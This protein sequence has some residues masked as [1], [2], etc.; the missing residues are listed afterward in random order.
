MPKN[1]L[2]IGPTGVGKTEISRR[3]A[4]LAGA[5]FIK[6]EAT[7]FT[8][9]GYVGR[10]V[11]QIM[12]DLVEVGIELVREKKREEV[13][14][15]A[16]LERRGARA[17]RAGRQDGQPGDARFVPQEAA[18]RANS[19]T[20]RSRSRSP[21]AATRWAASRFPACPAPIS[22]CST[23]TTCSARRFGQRTKTR[24]TTVE[25]VLRP[26]DRRRIR[27]AARQGPGGD[28]RRCRVGRE[29][30][31]RLPRRDRQDRARATATIGRQRLARRRAARPA[32]AGRGHDGRHQVRAGEDRPHPVHRVGRLPRRQAVGPAC[33]NCRAA[34]RSAS[35]CRR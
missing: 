30:R 5:P 34:C 4:K 7:K 21:T 9:V 18:R 32:A 6:V 11:E 15:K 26:A 12:R 2:M 14:A 1:I 20:R 13:K 17:R 27:Q 19:T 29:R 16:H 28:A 8:E 10:D 23:S 31:H 22:A 3:L 24:T 25:G 35:S 33:R